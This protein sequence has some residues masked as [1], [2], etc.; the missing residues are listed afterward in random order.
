LAS[1]ESLTA[2]KLLQEFIRGYDDDPFGEQG[3]VIVKQLLDLAFPNQS[4]SEIISSEELLELLKVAGAEYYFRKKPL[5][6]A[7]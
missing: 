1:I 4:L 2:G 5:F 7:F 3:L 6:M